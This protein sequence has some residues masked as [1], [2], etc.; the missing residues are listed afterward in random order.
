MTC[1]EK[2]RELR[3]SRHMSQ[4][5][6]ADAIG[7][8][9]NSIAQYENDLREPSFSVLKKIAEFFNVPFSSLLPSDGSAGRE[10]IQQVAD[11]LHQNPKLG[12]L[13]DRARFM[14]ESDLDAVL[15]VVNAISKERDANG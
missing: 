10:Y 15:A 13:F 8:S 7:M 11:S 12:L 5:Q 14:T 1:G 2:I 9:Q 3:K 4:Q 6:I